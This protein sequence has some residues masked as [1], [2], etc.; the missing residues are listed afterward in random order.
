MIPLV[1]VGDILCVHAAEETDANIVIQ[2]IITPTC[3]H[4]AMLS[5]NENVQLKSVKID[6]NNLDQ[7]YSCD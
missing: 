6:F 5:E 4:E 1:N 2:C 7:K 3:F